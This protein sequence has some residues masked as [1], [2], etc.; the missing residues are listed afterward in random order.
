MTERTLLDEINRTLGRVESTVEEV[1]DRMD[2]I[3]IYYSAQFNG[4]NDRLASLELDRSGFKGAAAA[5]GAMAGGLISIIA[6][7][8]YDW[9][10][11]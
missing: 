4:I 11:H 7:F 1:K 6:A 3:D 2:R 8:I 10:G 5:F 9:R